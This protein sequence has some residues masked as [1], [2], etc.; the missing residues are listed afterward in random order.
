MLAMPHWYI[1]FIV[2]TIVGG[3]IPGLL[4]VLV[5]YGVVLCVS[6]KKELW[7]CQHGNQE[8]TAD[9]YAK[10]EDCEGEAIKIGDRVEQ[11]YTVAG[12]KHRASY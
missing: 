9:E 2:P 10:A 7:G 11:E 1:G 12:G 4:V 6:C 8:A 5:P 3:I